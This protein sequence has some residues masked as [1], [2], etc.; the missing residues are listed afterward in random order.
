[1]N[2]VEKELKK[3]IKREQPVLEDKKSED[4]YLVGPFWFTGASLA[5]INK[6]K[7]NLLPAKFLMDYDGRYQSRVSKSQFTHKGLWEIEFGK[8]YPSKD[9]DYFPR[10]RVSWDSNEHKVWVNIPKGLNEEVLLPMVA[11]AYEFDLTLAEIKYTD[12]TTGNH[13]SFKLR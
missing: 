9:F 13:Y 2:N 10:G 7:C 5:Q 11:Q 6:G 12:P 3:Q 1:M 4:F 8:R